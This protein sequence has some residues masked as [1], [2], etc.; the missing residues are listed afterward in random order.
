TTALDANVEFGKKQRITG[1]PTLL[2]ADGTRVPG[3]VPIAQVEKLL[4]DI[5]P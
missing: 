2:F 3:A 5:K 1:T 4:N